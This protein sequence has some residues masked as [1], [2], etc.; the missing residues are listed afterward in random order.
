VLLPVRDAGP[1]LDACLDSLAA[2]TLAD[3]E[4]V[5]VDDGSGDGSGERLLARAVRDPRLRVLRTPPRG[6]VA[7]LS[8]AL[9]EARSPLVARMDA[10]DVARPSRLEA[11]VR[12]LREDPG[13][14]VLGCRV[15]VGALPGAAAG[16]G[17]RAYV[18]W[19][20]ALLDHD[21]IA[22]DRFVESPLVHPSVA[23]R[24]AALRA[25]GGWREFPGP[26]DY[27][28]WLRAFDAGLRFAK[29]PEVLLE[30]R[31]SPSRLTR[32]DARYAPAA[33]GRLK[34]EALARG[35]LAGRPAV[36]WGAGPVGKAFASALRE[37][38]VAVAAFVE[39]S[40]RKIGQ[41]VHGV[42]VVGVGDA[43]RLE[44]ALHVG[45]VGQKGARER[46]REEARRLG[47]VDGE[48]FFA[49]A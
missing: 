4:I 10:D 14:D 40:P 45:A 2:Q 21:A 46:L 27:D 19:A 15:S 43:R 20:N 38:G 17:M 28:L 16:E 5:A 35:P 37:K 26:E 44:P 34:A 11:Q 22:R 47:L 13:T 24:T 3:H 12:R 30:W 36:V 18:D 49:V 23:M 42:P 48:S 25:L 7:A 32:T 33:F 9:D 8:L 6:L 39:V 31:D 1:A 41:R 29:L